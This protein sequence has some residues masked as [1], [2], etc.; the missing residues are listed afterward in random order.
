MGHG[1]VDFVQTIKILLKAGYD[2][3]YSFEFEGMENPAEAIKNS[4]E[5]FKYYYEEA[6]RQIHLT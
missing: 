5:N 6:Q 1:V 2:G 4:L 3:Y